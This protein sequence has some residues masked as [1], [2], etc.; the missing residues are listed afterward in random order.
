MGDVAQLEQISVFRRCDSDTDCIN[1][2]LPPRWTA[3]SIDFCF[4]ARAPAPSTRTMGARK[5]RRSKQFA[6]RYADLALDRDGIAM[7][8]TWRTAM[9][10]SCQRSS[11]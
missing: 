3:A 9:S 4:C 7:A 5:D 11:M 2:G 10:T 1:K 8:H 6:V